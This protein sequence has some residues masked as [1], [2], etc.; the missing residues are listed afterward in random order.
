MRFVRLSVWVNHGSGLELR[1]IVGADR[2]AKAA[3]EAGSRVTGIRE[4][5]TVSPL[6]LR[7]M[8]R[9][10][11]KCSDEMN[12]GLPGVSQKRTTKT[13]KESGIRRQGWMGRA[14]KGRV[15]GEV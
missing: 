4:D 3:A 11:E 6:D 1:T 8:R 5:Q 2:G 9:R 7:V 13:R 14:G 15:G 10:A 12:N